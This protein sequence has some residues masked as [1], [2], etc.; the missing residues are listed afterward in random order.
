MS[1]YCVFLC[2]RH[3]KLSLAKRYL[4]RANTAMHAIQVATDKHPQY[5]PIGVEPLYDSTHGHVAVKEV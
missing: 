4:I 2:R 3:W 1:A 5:H